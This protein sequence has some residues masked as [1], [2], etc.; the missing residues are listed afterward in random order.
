MAS[1]SL[2]TIRCR[3]HKRNR[4]LRYPLDQRSQITWFVAR[5]DRSGRVG[6]I[7]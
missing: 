3:D 2:K 7:L 4:R 6:E 5:P 1:P